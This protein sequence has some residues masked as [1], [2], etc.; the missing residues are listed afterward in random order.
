M[1]LREIAIGPL[2]ALALAACG[3]NP[4]PRALVLEEAL[5]DPRPGVRTRAVATVGR[6]GD[7]RYVPDLIELLDDPDPGVRLSAG[8]VLE[9]LTG[10]D[11]GYEP[12]ADEPARRRQL[13]DW[14]AW[15][16]SRSAPSGGPP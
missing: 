6:Q 7:V 12:W 4:A 9:E 1:R 16:A 13:A 5:T 15:W 11:T 10:R 14:R 3:S 8:A 2:L